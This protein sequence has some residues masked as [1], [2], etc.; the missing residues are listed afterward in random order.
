MTP[1]R[2]F[3]LAILFIACVH[4]H[5]LTAD[6]AFDVVVYGA[7]PGGVTAAVGAAREGATVALVEPTRHIG[8]VN[9]GGLSFSDSNQTVRSTLL[10]LFEE[11]HQ[12][13]EADY[14]QRGIKLPYSV[15]VKDHAVWTYEPHVAARVTNVLLSEA[16][17]AVFPAHILTKVE[18]AGAAITRISTHTGDTFIAKAFVDATYEGDLMAAA[19][20]SWTI[21]REGRAVYNESLAGRQYPKKPMAISGFDD[22]GNLLPLIT[23][24]DA[25]ADEEGDKRVM[26]YSFRL[27]VT[28]DPALRVPFPA[29]KH[30]D[31]ARFEAV[32]RYY[33]ADP[34]APFPWDLYP[35]PGKKFDANNGI[36]KHFSMGIVGACN[37]WSE[38]N[39]EERDRIW[40]EHQQYTLE[41]YH[42]FATDPAIPAGIR[43]RMA[44][45]GLCKDEF[46]EYGHWSPQLYVREGR[47]MQGVQVI[48]QNDIITDPRKED[49]I[50][51][52]SFPIDS[53][54]VQ[55]IAR[56]DGTVINEG[57]IMPVH[58]PG[59][60]QGPAY[61]ISYRAI[62]PKMEECTN[63]LVPVALSC[64]HVAFS[65]IRV[66]P[67]WMAIGQSAGIAAALAAKEKIPVQQL[68]YA[69]LKERLLAQKQV[70]ELPDQPGRE[71]LRSLNRR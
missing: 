6:H 65:S 35:I 16:K 31:P 69:T 21:G 22:A 9:S 61:H 28:E 26:V 51:I 63:L 71:K 57:T 42:F 44:G 59:T 7:T 64:T 4:S 53:H 45:L 40:E 49:P 11:F 66:E 56:P 32:R 2:R 70:L 39:Q 48:T 25:G 46:A 33:L 20:V 55:R 10:G 18:K 30:Y 54:D 34:K 3:I 67:T 37:G 58:V 29:P 27:C 19:G 41:M 62:T 5:A 23:T 1:T 24:K 52:S 43:T 13:I 38:A 36:N 14:R 50:A 68:D 60:R 15:V 47:R 12:R 8:G 17:V